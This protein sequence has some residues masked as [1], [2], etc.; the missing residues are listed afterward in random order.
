MTYDYIIGWDKNELKVIISS[1]VVSY[2]KQYSKY[3]VKEKKRL[4]YSG[5]TLDQCTRLLELI[6]ELDN[7]LIY[8]VEYPYTDKLHRNAYSSFYSTQNNNIDKDCIRVS[9]FRKKKKS[10]KDIRYR[11]FN[12]VLRH[13]NF[14][15]FF[16]I[17]PTEPISNGRAII[18]PSAL[19]CKPFI[20]CLAKYVVHVQGV[21]LKVK[22]FP[23]SP[24]DGV[25]YS[26]AET[27]IW[28]MMEY[29]GAK[30]S[31]YGTILP[32]DIH[33]VIKKIS[34]VRQLPSNGLSIDQI[35]YT[36]RKLGF[37]SLYYA[38]SKKDDDLSIDK[39]E[40]VIPDYIESGIPV[41][42]IVEN[43][44]ETK[45][46]AM[47]VI[48]HSIPEKGRYKVK[49]KNWTKIQV[50]AENSYKGTNNILNTFQ[51]VDNVK[52]VEKEFIFIDDNKPPYRQASLG[53]PG[54]HYS[55]VEM[56]STGIITII[57]P[58]Y[59]KIYLDNI[60]ARHLFS[61][62][63]KNPF[64]GW[65][66]RDNSKIVSRLLL[67]S[68]KSFKK[69][70]KT[71]GLR[72]KP[73]LYLLKIAMPKF[74]WIVEL[75]SPELYEKNKALGLLIFDSTSTQFEKIENYLISALYPDRILTK[76]SKGLFERTENG[77]SN[78]FP[79][80]VNNLKNFN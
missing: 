44:Q 31:Y 60:N 43:S 77:L 11:S 74:I 72:E 35:A 19:G 75:S 25:A 71:S 49:G 61:T 68:S 48:G 38:P 8:F 24:Q 27:A 20:S 9:I 33:K 53:K 42:A 4:L 30:Y 41:I 16:I 29:F 47:I 78:H 76:D 67:T 18:N 14:I 52:N 70:V 65:L 34:Y 66:D 39:F 10:S 12:Q 45:R 46:H 50:V 1:F 7:D 2:F 58:L 36:L 22:G 73:F 63:I 37:G 6:R 3:S 57:V 64:Y 17:R 54:I 23:Y 15:G 40:Y 69:W 80:Y 26:C 5:K 32:S 55:D 62:L 21:E 13:Y 51:I 28:A 59:P 79:M 56:A